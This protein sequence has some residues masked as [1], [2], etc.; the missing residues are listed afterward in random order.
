M[1]SRFTFI[2]FIA[3]AALGVSLLGACSST[4]D[5][6]GNPVDATQ[7]TIDPAKWPKTIS[8][9]RLGMDLAIEM[10]R[11]QLAPGETF[12]ATVS[13]KNTSAQPQR[14]S[15]PTSQRFELIIAKDPEG[16]EP[17]AI[18]SKGYS[19]LQMMREVTLAPGES[20]SDRLEVPLHKTPEEVVP[21]LPGT[22]LEPG[23][24]FVIASHPG[25]SNLRTPGLGIAVSPLIVQ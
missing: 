15:W 6:G 18:W 5:S 13:L 7:R 1:K 14:I 12:A 4:G 20:V 9:G 24:Y 11:T 10:E 8:M 2:A 17:V 23:F 19:F 16:R 22:Y 25:S 3:A 21:D